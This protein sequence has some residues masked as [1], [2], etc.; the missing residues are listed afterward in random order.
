M[1]I[2]TDLDCTLTGR[3]AYA[4]GSRHNMTRH[5]VVHAFHAGTQC[6]IAPEVASSYYTAKVDIYSAGSYSSFPLGIPSALV[7]LQLMPM[8]A[9]FFL[10]MPGR[11]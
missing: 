2:A 3:P 10:I 7:L 8:P 4:V 9:V 1:S 6:Y 11:C 5:S